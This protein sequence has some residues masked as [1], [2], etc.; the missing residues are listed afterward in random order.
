L[1]YDEEP[2]QE[3]GYCY[4]RREWSFCKPRYLTLTTCS[5]KF[6]NN[7]CYSRPYV[8][9]NFLVNLHQDQAKSFNLSSLQP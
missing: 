9:N 2:I 8:R 1:V 3:W 6:I 5:R 7:V 4:W